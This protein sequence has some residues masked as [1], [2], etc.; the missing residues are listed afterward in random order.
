MINNKIAVK[1]TTGF[2][3]IVLLSML[4]IG[5]LFIQM[6]R[7]YAFESREK[8]L[9]ELAESIAQVV[10]EY[11]RS[12]GSMRGF[13]GFMR[14]LDTLSEAHVWITDQQGN[15]ALMSGMGPGHWKQ[16]E[17]LPPEANNVVADVLAGKKTVSQS[18]SSVYNEATLTV[19]VPIR[20]A[21]GQVTGSVLL[22]APVTGVTETLNKAVKILLIS[23]AVALVL[24]AGLGIFYSRRFTRPL[25]TMNLAALEMAKGHYTVKTGIDRQ[26]EIGQL[27]RSLDLL[28][29][30]LDTTINQLFQEKGKLND[31]IA[32]ISEGIFALD[33][34]MRP[35]SLNQAL[36]AIMGR[37]QTYDHQMLAVDLAALEIER[38]FDKVLTQK[39]PVSVVKEWLGKK[40]KITLAPILDNRGE[41]AGC[42]ALV[43]DISESER[44]EQM[45]RDFVANVSHEFR[46][47]L[48][49]IRGSLEALLDG[50]VTEKSAAERYHRRMLTETRGLE[51]LVGDLLDLARFQAGKITVNK[52]QLDLGQLLVAVIKSL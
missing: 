52:E 33:K 16:S 26:D 48:T 49:I 45:R 39:T 3:L 7:Q 27:G 18:F 23:L 19:G 35:L 21:A 50:T 25:Q 11:S 34:K 51:R 42:V 15:P 8:V 14:F 6:F 31:I 5:V 17:P 44:L 24:A 41:A 2:I 20:D 38:E 37:P 47:P 40:L 1:L 9:L 10:A 28:A 22:H 32:S 4:T 36:A 13:G 43:Q 29:T 30:R 12:N 46:T